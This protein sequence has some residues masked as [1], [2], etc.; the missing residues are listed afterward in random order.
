MATMK[1][2]AGTSASS[3]R[4]L[5]SPIELKRTNEMIWSENTGRAQSG[6]NKAKMIGDVVAQKRTY[7]IKWGVLTGT[8]LNIIINNLPKGFFSFAAA[9]S[10]S[11]AEEAAGR[12]YRSEIS[13]DYLQAGRE[14]L[15]KDVSVSVIEQ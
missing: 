7:T 11:A 1:I 2:Y 14:V 13:F 8:Q 12:Y 15:Y 3:M 6:S 5:P 10:A 9:T 4:E